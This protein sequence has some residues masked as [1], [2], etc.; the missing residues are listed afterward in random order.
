MGGDRPY[1][2]SDA[3]HTHVTSSLSSPSSAFRPLVSP[4]IR[5]LI[6]LLPSLTFPST[7]T[8]NLEVSHIFDVACPKHHLAHLPI[9][10]LGKFR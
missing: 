4:I 2:D 7:F 8:P 9:Q 10:T 3:E 1:S 6:A 5:V